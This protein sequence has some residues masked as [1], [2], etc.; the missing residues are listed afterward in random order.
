MFAQSEHR[1][2]QPTAATQVQLDHFSVVKQ[3]LPSAVHAI[4]PHVQ[5]AGVVRHGQAL[6]RLLFDH[7]DRDAARVDLRDG[8]ED[9]VDDLRR[10]AG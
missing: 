6:T 10:Q 9:L 2:T 4:L 1:V 7:Q 8:G 3:L 5:H